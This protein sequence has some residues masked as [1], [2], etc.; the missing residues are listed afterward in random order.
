MLTRLKAQGYFRVIGLT[1][2]I[3]S[4]K[5]HA[6]AYLD[7]LGAHTVDADSICHR[8]YEPGLASF[9]AI[10]GEFGSG[11]LAPDGQIDRAALGKIVFQDKKA[12]ETLESTW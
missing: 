6:R 8:A 11:V 7:E 4:G 1:G 2:N 10:V 12:L 3:A 5:S 9:D